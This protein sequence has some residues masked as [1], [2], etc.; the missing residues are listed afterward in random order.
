[1]TTVTISDY[2]AGDTLVMNVLVTDS[3]GAAIDLTGATLKW[4]IAAGKPTDTT[5]A[6]P[7]LLLTQGD[8]ITVVDAVAGSVRVVLDEGRFT[9][10]GSFVHELEV[11]LASGESYT[12]ARGV[13]KSQAAV[14]PQ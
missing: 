1:M 11:E 7:L 6:T 13:L 4:A 8:G 12:V 14:L 10:A 5:Y 2:V 9:R 3:K